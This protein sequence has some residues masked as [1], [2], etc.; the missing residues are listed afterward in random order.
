MCDRSASASVGPASIYNVSPTG[1]RPTHYLRFH[2]RRVHSIFA[3]EFHPA[4]VT[5]HTFRH[6]ET[7]GLFQDILNKGNSW[8]YN[9]EHGWVARH[10]RGG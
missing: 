4:G 7:L 1:S 5:E 10:L 3:R 2:F 9:E 8:V 6:R